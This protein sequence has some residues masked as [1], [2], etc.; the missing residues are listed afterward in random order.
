MIA[1]K[2]RDRDDQRVSAVLLS[3]IAVA[4]TLLG[5]STTYVFQR[6]TALHTEAAARRERLRQDRLQACGTFV[7]AV[8]EVKRAVIT[9]WF[10]RE[11]RDDERREA[12]T[13]ADRMGAAAE[14][15]LI[16]LLLVN[17]DAEL[18]RLADAVSGHIAVIR[19]A[20]DKAE[21]E[22]ARRRSRRRGKRSSRLPVGSLADRGADACPV[23]GLERPCQTLCFWTA[24]TLMTA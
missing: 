18:R 10:R 5:S 14:G 6:R 16:R 7:A 11:V 12:M 9:A 20:A 8:T 3:L 21:L 17:D 19:A 1:C 13:E 22:A 23:A 2:R 24:A 15:A 4:G